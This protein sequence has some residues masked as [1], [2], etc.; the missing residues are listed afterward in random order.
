MLLLPRNEID[1]ESI[2]QLQ[3]KFQPHFSF[4]EI[5]GLNSSVLC[6]EVEHIDL[7][8]LADFLWTPSLER[9]QLLNKLHSRIDIDWI[10]PAS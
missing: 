6:E 5:D 10:D 9:G 3:Q 1:S 2:Q 4:A 7:M 8:R